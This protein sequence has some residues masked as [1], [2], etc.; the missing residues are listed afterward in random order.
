MV[1]TTATATLADLG[2]LLDRAATL[3]ATATAGEE[4]FGV[5]ATLRGESALRRVVS[6]ASVDE[7]ARVDLV[8][9]VFGGAVGEVAL[10]VVTEAVRRRW[11][12]SGELVEVVEQLGVVALVRSAGA[13]SERITDELFALVRVIE[14]SPE[15]R[16][17]LADTSRP[18]ADRFAL[19]RGLLDGKVL[20]ATLSLVGHAVAAATGSVERVLGDY[21]QVAAG[22]QDELLATIRVARDLS[23]ADRDRLREALGRQYDRTVRLRVV[24]E[25]DLVGGLRVEIGDDV[26]DGSVSGRLDDARRRLAG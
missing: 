12:L 15:L 5:A 21:Q 25:P 3:E 17:A 14:E 11:R 24:V 20:P 1:S 7:A 9:Q 26:I 8:R 10:A 16:S 19:L 4:L 22:V 6:D 18:A 2:E 13:R 23:S